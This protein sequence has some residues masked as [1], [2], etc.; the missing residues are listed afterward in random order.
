MD[1]LW[2]IFNQNPQLAYQLFIIPL[3]FLFYSLATQG[4]LTLFNRHIYLALGGFVLAILTMGPY[5]MLLFITNII[6]VLLVRFMEPVHIHYWIFGLQ[7]W[8]QTLWH[9]YMQYQ[10]YWLQESPDSRLVLAMSALMLLS[11]RVTSVSMDL[12]E[13]KV[14][15]HFQKSCQSQVVSLIPFMSYTLYFPALLGGPLCPFNTYVNFVE[16]ISFTPPPSPL[17]ILPWK[18]LQVLLLLILKFLLTSFLQSSIFSLS[19]SPCILWIWIFSLVLRLNYYVHW[20]ISECVNSAAGLGFSGYSATGGALWNGLSDGDA[21]EIETSSNISTFARLWNRTTAAWLRRL[22]FQRCSRIPV[23]MTFSFS[24]LWHGLYPGQVVGFLGWAVAVLGDNKLHK[25]IS[26]SLNTA[27][28]KGLY[29]CLSW[30]YT[31]VV[32]AFV[33]I[34]TE[35]QSLEAFKLFCT[36]YIALFPLASILI[37]LIL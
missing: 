35:L 8:W 9:F 3:A 32:I 7:M 15:R 24:A 16:Q 4:Y 25:H 6:F 2:I 18:M 10:Q 11:Q 27:W 29:T 19:S 33:V 23:L 5:S 37:L 13:G 12:Q 30:L 1:L 20:K 14:I 21:L 28:K 26:P 34:T 36:T 31:Q 22:V 17:T